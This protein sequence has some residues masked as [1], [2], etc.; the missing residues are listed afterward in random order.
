MAKF[1]GA[2]SS[3]SSSGKKKINSIAEKLQRSLYLVKPRPSSSNDTNAV[4]QDVKEGHFAVI[5]VKGDE[6][7]RFVVPL[8]CLAHP[9]FLR[10][11]EQA[12][13]EYGF[14]REGALNI[15]CRPCELEK[16]L[17]EQWPQTTSDESSSSFKWGSCKTHGAELLVK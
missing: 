11:L 16:I 2:S 14:D 7:K 6:P 15:P 5:A 1:R 8:S 9:T 4:P 10:L 13:E 12:A 17:A 3:S